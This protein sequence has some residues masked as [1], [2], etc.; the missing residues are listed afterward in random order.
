MHPT[1]EDLLDQL[2][3]IGGLEMIGPE[4]QALLL[5]LWRKSMKLAWART[6]V[7]T[8][9][10][11]I[12]KAGFKNRESLNNHRNKLVQAGLIQYKAPPRGKMDG[13]YTL[14]F[15]LVG[16]IRKKVVREPVSVADNLTDNILDNLVD[17]LPY[18]PTDNLADT[19]VSKLVS[20]KE[21][22]ID[23]RARDSLSLPGE[24]ETLRQDFEQT[25]RLSMKASHYEMVNSYLEEG[26]QIE[27]ILLALEDARNN[28]ASYPRYLWRIL[29]SWSV[30]GI[31]TISDYRRH[32]QENLNTSGGND[33]P[34]E[35][36]PGAKKFQRTQGLSKS[37]T[38]ILEKFKKAGLK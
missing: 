17:N 21:G 2:E 28:E 38:E 30:K 31:K 20:K 22:R 24:W 37:K 36:K 8:N 18:N 7:M 12:Y 26:M 33:K 11:L 15:D 23:T 29:D 19:N 27:L 9:T 6:F 3:N 14:E 13:T 35:S 16:A 34:P 4:G 1:L 10:E 32:I 5:A 25:F